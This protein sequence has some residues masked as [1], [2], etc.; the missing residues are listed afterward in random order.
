MELNLTR[1]APRG[2]VPKDL[3]KPLMSKTSNAFFPFPKGWISD[4]EILNIFTRLI[5]LLSEDWGVIFFFSKWELKKILYTT[6]IGISNN[7]ELYISY[8]HIQ[9]IASNCNSK[10]SLFRSVFV[11]IRT[12]YQSNN[13]I[14]GKKIIVNSLWGIFF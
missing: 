13:L 4:S 12:Y 1:N 5:F 10:M 6:S 14:R 2:G 7:Y 8:L 3:V 11:E 9:K